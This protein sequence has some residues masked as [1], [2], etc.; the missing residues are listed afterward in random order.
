MLGSDVSPIEPDRIV[1]LR[2]F[3]ASLRFRDALAIALTSG[4]SLVGG[5][6]GGGGGFVVVGV[7]GGGGGGGG[8]GGVGIFG[9]NGPTHIERS[10]S[11]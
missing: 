8:G 1:E 11:F 10:F 3:I 6:S 4:S 5:A 9:A 2:P 7:A